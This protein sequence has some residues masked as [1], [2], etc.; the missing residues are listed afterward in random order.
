M[1]YELK[2]FNKILKF[3]D[4]KNLYM[5]KLTFY[6]TLMLRYFLLNVLWTTAINESGKW[7]IE[8]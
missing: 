3:V 2:K 6:K 4:F 8:F 1:I 5:K 7:E